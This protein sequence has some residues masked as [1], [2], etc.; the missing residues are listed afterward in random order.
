MTQLTPASP[1]M[2]RVGLPNDIG[3]IMAELLDGNLGWVN[4]Q[5]I[6]ASGGIHS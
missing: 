4:G 5:R 3:A 1:T 2:G 6:E